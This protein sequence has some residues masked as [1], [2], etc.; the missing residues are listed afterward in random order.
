M[1]LLNE[2]KDPIFLPFLCQIG[3]KY[4]DKLYDFV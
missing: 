2:H 4:R 3:L 1:I